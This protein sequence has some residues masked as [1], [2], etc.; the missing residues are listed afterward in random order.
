MR[1]VVWTLV[2]ALIGACGDDEPVPP[3]TEHERS[4]RV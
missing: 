3:A 1:S 4:T 2:V